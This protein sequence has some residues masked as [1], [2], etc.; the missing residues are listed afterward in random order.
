MP[1]RP[2]QFN[3]TVGIDL[4]WI[5]DVADNTYYLFNILDLATGFNLGLCLPNKSPKTLSQAFKQFWI[6]W[7]GAPVKIVADQGR[8]GFGEFEECARHLGAAFKMTSLEAPW[9]NGMVERHGGVLGHI[10]EAVVLETS[11]VGHA[12]MSDI[13]LHASMAKNRRPGRTGYS[14]R[15]L[16]FGCDERLIASGLNH[17]LEQPDDAAITAS[18]TDSAYRRSMDFR[19][20]A[21]KAVIEL[22]HSEKWSQAIKMPSRPEVPNVFLPGN[23]VFFWRTAGKAKKGRISRSATACWEGPAVVI[24]HEWDDGVQKNSYW[25]RSAGRCRLV[26]GKTYVLP[27]W[28]KCSHRTNCW[29]NSGEALLSSVQNMNRLSSMTI[30]SRSTWTLTHVPRA[31]VLTILPHLGNGTPLYLRDKVSPSLKQWANTS[32]PWESVLPRPLTVTR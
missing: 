28:K 2:T 29:R 5:K 16:V 1:Y 22:D 30:G 27:P 10:I 23:Q 12:Q 15:S 26:P 11:P 9:Q 8:E 25:I 4:K 20:V 24:G 18:T 31:R 14:P 17:Y 21:M 7:A 13:C 19:R 3:H 32:D 6:S